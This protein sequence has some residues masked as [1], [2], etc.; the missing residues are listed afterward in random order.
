MTDIDTTLQTPPEITIDSPMADNEIFLGTI[1][2]DAYEPNKQGKY[3]W[4]LTVKPVDFSIGGSTGAFHTYS[5][6]SENKKSKFANMKAGFAGLGLPG[7][8]GFA[9]GQLLGLVAWFERRD[10]NAGKNKDTG[11]DF[12]FEGVLIPTRLGTAEEIERGKAIYA[13][14]GNADAPAA[15]APDLEWDDATTDTVVSFLEGK[16]KREFQS[17]AAKSTFA[18]PIKSAIMSGKALKYLLEAE[19]VELDDEGKVRVLQAA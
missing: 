2:G 7:T 4:H 13:G 17:A 16:S 6:L 5:Y 12:I 9:K 19:L 1:I 11:E 15:A 3:Q 18:P 14:T 10:I 8:T